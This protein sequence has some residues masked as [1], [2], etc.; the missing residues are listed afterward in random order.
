MISEVTVGL[1]M[2]NNNRKSTVHL[3][4]A[5]SGALFCLKSQAGRIPEAFLRGPQ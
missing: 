1:L 2:E 3:P 5:S 4:R